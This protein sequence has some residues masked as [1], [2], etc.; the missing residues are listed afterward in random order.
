[1]DEIW[2]SLLNGTTYELANIDLITLENRIIQ[3]KLE[4]KSFLYFD[5]FQ[6]DNKGKTLIESGLFV[7]LEHFS[8]AYIRE[9]NN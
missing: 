8:S 5:Y 2:I 3:A 4:K 1:M 6:H 9:S 7:S